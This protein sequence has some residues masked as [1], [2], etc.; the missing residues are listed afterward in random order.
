MPITLL[1][2][3]F[4]TLGRS[5]TEQFIDNDEYLKWIKVIFDIFDSG[6][7]LENR[8][9][10]LEQKL[11]NRLDAGEHFQEADFDAL[12]KEITGRDQAWADL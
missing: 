7:D 4:T 11:A 2:P 10:A 6:S 3:L 5:L 8:F 1:L 12:V 9:K